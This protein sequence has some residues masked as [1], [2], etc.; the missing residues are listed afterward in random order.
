MLICVESFSAFA[1]VVEPGEIK[2]Q[3]MITNLDQFPGFTYYYLHHGYHYN[4]GWKADTPDTV[5]VENNKTYKVALKG[6]DKTFLMA[7]AMTNNNN[8]YFKSDLEMGGSVITD[9]SV[10]GI[11][12]VYQIMERQNGI[13]K[14]KKIKEIIQYNNG[15]EEERKSG[16]IWLG[17]SGNN[18]F[19]KGLA[20]LASIALMALLLLFIVKRSRPH[21]FQPATG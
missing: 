17:F 9:P 3:F 16:S 18:N 19:T 8:L 15:K 11:V 4:M 6:N 20:A 1:D 5:L 2:K 14:L 7:L 10:K 13:I 12:E 21:N